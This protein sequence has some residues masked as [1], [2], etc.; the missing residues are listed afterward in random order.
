MAMS[1]Q[2]YVRSNS[3]K[4][5]IKASNTPSK[6]PSQI[7]IIRVPTA[8]SSSSP[9]HTTYHIYHEKYRHA[10]ISTSPD[11]R[12]DRIFSPS[13]SDQKARRTSKKFRLPSALPPD[14]TAFFLHKPYLTLHNPP[15]GLYAGPHP[16]I[17]IHSGCLWRS[18]T[19]Q[20]IPSLATPGILDPRGVV[21]WKHNG[22]SKKTLQQNEKL[23][24]GYKVRTWRL[25][26]E[27][28]KEYVHTIR[29]LR[30]GGGKNGEQDP[31]II[32]PSPKNTP[33]YATEIVHLHWSSPF[34]FHTRQ[35]HFS[36]R[37]TTFSWKGT[38][39]VNESRRCGMFLRFNHLKLVARVPAEKGE[40]EVC[41]G[42]YT[43]SIAKKKS[44]V[45]ELFDGAVVRFAEEHAL[46]LLEECLDG[47]SE[48]RVVEDDIDVK[49]AK[50]K[51]SALYQVIVATAL[52][53]IASE[54]EKRH[55]LIDILVEAA[56]Q[57]GGGGS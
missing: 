28:G 7:E 49:I 19:L 22:G 33:A 56:S 54:K 36:F 42:K 1:Q 43:S 20:L 51:K 16:T 9:T 31:D 25:W 11:P 26:S 6:L 52:C 4:Q 24:K 21:C 29:K 10:I 40:H 17:L 13:L 48:E 41:L 37:G 32:P 18:Y 35:Y 53:M 50:L 5:T 34:S 3:H 57:G 23:L 55:T 12:K 14:E 38:G 39:T 46:G 47:E 27:S 15:S 8:N 30:R 2:H 45:L 44:G